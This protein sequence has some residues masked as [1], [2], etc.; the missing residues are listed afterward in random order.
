MAVNNELHC[1]RREVSTRG[2]LRRLRAEGRVPGILY[3]RGQENIPVSFDS[4]ELKRVFGQRG[5]RGLFSLNITGERTPVLALVREVQQDPISK[6][7]I[8]IDFMRVNMGEKI[9][10]DVPV[11]FTGEDEL[12]KRGLVLQAMI[13]DVEVEC[14]PVD[15]PEVFTVDVSGLVEGGRLTVGD[16]KAPEGVKII[17]E[18]DTVVAVAVYAAR[19]DEEAHEEAEAEA[20]A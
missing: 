11:V 20:G 5:S 8:H 13:K 17:T 18:P 12:L 19:A 14:L 2:H 3:G 6:N 9:K 16:L 10:A 4:A 1:H 7:V 15:L